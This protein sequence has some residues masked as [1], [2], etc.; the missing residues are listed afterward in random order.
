MLIVRVSIDHYVVSL[1][2]LSLV[3]PA[4]D[5]PYVDLVVSY[6]SLTNPEDEEMGPHVRYYV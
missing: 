5:K 2:M 6:Q 4:S 3:K 1:S